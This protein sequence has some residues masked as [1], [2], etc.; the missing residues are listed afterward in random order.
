MFLLS[1]AIVLGDF[2]IN[3]RR[4]AN[5]FISIVMR[6]YYGRTEAFAPIGKACRTKTRFLSA[7]SERACDFFSL[8]YCVSL[9]IDRKMKL[10]KC[11]YYCCQCCGSVTFWDG[12]GH[13]VLFNDL[14][15]STKKNF[16]VFL[17]I[18]FGSYIHIIF[19]R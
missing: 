5:R 10:K 7:S 1:T 17:L 6:Q 4:V 14:H 3:R 18:T 12:S 15:N 11:C 19:Q 9:L 13:A 16:Y 8:I 2:S